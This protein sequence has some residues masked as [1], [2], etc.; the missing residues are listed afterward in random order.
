MTP[1]SFTGIGLELSADRSLYSVVLAA[2]ESCPQR[3]SLCTIDG[4]EFTCAQLADRTR[5][6]AGA[7][8]ERGVAPGDR[9]AILGRTGLDWALL[10][11]A[12]LAIGAVI[13]PIYPT[14]SAHQIRHILEDS[15]AEHFAAETTIDAERLICAGGDGIW[16]FDDVAMWPAPAELGGVDARI[17]QVAADDLAMIV[18]TSGTTGLPKG[19]KLSHRNMYASAANT[20]LHTSSMFGGTSCDQAVTA[21]GLPLAHVFGQTILF[22][23][24][25]GGTRTYLLPGIPELL[26]VLPVVRPTFLALVPYALEK[27][28]KASRQRLSVEAENDAVGRGLALLHGVT[29]DEKHDGAAELDQLGGRLRYVISGGASLDQS[30]SGFFAGFGVQILNCYGMTETATATTVNQPGSNRL[31]TVGRPIPATTVGIDEDGEI[32]VRG[33][34]VTPGYW[35]AAAAQCP[36]DAD[37]WLH[38]GDIGQIDANG[39]LRITGRKKEILVTSGGK[40]VAPTPLEDRIR[41]HPLVSNAIVLGDGRSFVTALI[42]LDE[43]GHTTWRA[44]NDASDSRADPA[45]LAELQTAIDDANSLVSRA[46]SIRSFRLVD[47]DFTPAN[48]LL[49]S[50]LKLKRAAIEAAFLADVDVLY[51]ARA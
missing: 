7:L 33:S 51:M 47:G 2:A 6:L 45:L 16:L 42:T 41:L 9:I 50:S 13:V 34:N 25:V 44:W 10:D 27:I 37:G 17:E 30:T 43:S 48:G 40:N 39:F 20:V 46:E 24:L 32:L 36:V 21:L 29:G 38:T 28:R 12:A 1:I 18:Y 19:C 14:S 4:R 31:G 26:A 23:C 11:L 15:G 5:A 3:P 35:G 22:A 8:M 49:T